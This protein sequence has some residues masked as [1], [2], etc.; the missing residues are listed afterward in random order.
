M[1]IVKMMVNDQLSCCS[2]FKCLFIVSVQITYLVI[3]S[4]GYYVSHVYNITSLTKVYKCELREHKRI[5]L[6]SLALCAC[7]K[8]VQ[9]TLLLYLA[10][11]SLSWNHITVMDKYVI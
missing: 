9:T 3:L 10:D 4:V 11:L 7:G 5:V 8:L 6:N 1:K 2:P